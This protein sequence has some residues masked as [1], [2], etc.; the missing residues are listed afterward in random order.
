MTPSRAAL[1]P[2]VPA[3]LE[4]GDGLGDRLVQFV[5]EPGHVG[6]GVNVTGCHSPGVGAYDASDEG[7]R[8]RRSRPAVVAGLVSTS[9]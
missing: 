3:F 1:G 2:G 7:R 4:L 5:G 8:T 6:Q 9:P